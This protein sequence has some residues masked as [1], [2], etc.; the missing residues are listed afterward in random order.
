MFEGE[1][2]CSLAPHARSEQANPGRTAAPGFGNV[3]DD[4]FQHVLLGG[5][6]R[7]ELL[8]NA[9]GRTC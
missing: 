7:I 2:E 8:A 3:G 5:D 6:R 1:P 4:F 9:I